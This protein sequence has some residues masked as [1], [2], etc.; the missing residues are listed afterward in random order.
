MIPV[1]GKQKNSLWQGKF[2]KRGRGE[3]PKA[4]SVLS[5]SNAI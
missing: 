3:I 4:Q 2:S 5:R 1:V